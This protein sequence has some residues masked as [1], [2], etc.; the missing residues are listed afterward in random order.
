MRDKKQ[1]NIHS[2]LIL[3]DKDEDFINNI[4][5]NSLSV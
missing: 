5:F 3:K 1:I 4:L 2:A